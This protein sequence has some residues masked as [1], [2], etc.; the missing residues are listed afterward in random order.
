MFQEK[1]KTKQ[2]NKKTEI[3]SSSPPLKK[4]KYIYEKK[5]YVKVEN[6]QCDKNDTM[7][8]NIINYA[9]TNNDK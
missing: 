9:F 7:C 2:T 4:K 3:Q 1:W 8:Q 5:N 6:N